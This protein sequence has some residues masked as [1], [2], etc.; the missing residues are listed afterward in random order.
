[1]R[2]EALGFFLKRPGL[3]LS[4]QYRAFNQAL[5][6]LYGD[7]LPATFADD[8]KRPAFDDKKFFAMAKRIFQERGFNASQLATAE[9]QALIAETFGVL[10]DAISSSITYE[11]PEILTYALENNAFVF[12]GF[13]TFHAIREVGLSLTDSDGSI[14]PFERFLNDVRKI[15]DRY[16]H[17]YLRAE[18]NQA[19]AASQMAARWHQFEQDGDD[20]Y[21]QYRTAGDANVREEHAIL[22]N[23]TLPISDPFWAEFLPPNGWNCRCTAVQVRKDK[24]PMSDPELAMKHGRNCTDGAKRQIFRFNPGK[25]MRLFPERH[26]YMPKGCGDCARKL[27]LAYSPTDKKCQVCDEIRRQARIK[28]NG[29]LYQKLLDDPNYKDVE[30]NPETGA[31]KATHI[32]HNTHP[33]DKLRYFG[34]TMTSDDL[35]N[36]FMQL[37]FESGRSVIFNDEKKI[38][39]DRNQ[40]S[41]LDMIFD[42]VVMDL[43][44]ITKLK[45]FYGNAIKAK[46]EQLLK[47]N[48]REDVAVKSHTICLYFHDASMYSPEKISNGVTWMKNNPLTTDIAVKVIISAL[49]TENGLKIIRHEI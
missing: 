33:N 11:V 28:Q 41:S 7:G 42:G 5:A 6:S 3:L 1:M 2:A 43:K 12:S 25:T 19:V 27:N 26:P 45:D 4:R 34:D 44:S 46:N 14:K 24:Y 21:L 10:R 15:N 37:A 18:Y 16:N 47:Y 29:E 49:R 30:F 48:K 32:G 17:N 38:G 8:K 40:L 23:T 31:L 9:G 13:K 20:Y 39:E 35:E 22:H 36:E